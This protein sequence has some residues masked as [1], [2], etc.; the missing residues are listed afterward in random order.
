M[1]FQALVIRKDDQGYR[2]AIEAVD[3]SDRLRAVLVEI[4]H[5]N[6][7][8]R[9]GWPLLVGPVVRSFPMVGYRLCR[10]RAGKQ[11]EPHGP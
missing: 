11:L 10:D 3:E 9:T 4:A 2:A 7:N 8:Y 1:S 5:S 6:L